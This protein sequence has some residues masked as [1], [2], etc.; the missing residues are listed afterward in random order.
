[1]QYLSLNRSLPESWCEF[2][3]NKP[4]DL[5]S[6]QIAKDAIV[7][8]ALPPARDRFKAFEMVDPDKIRIVIVGQD[9]YHRIDMATGLA[10]SVPS[11]K[12]IPPSLRN[13][14][15]EYVDDLGLRTP[16]H[17]DLS[18]WASRGVLLL[19][20]VLTVTEGR[21]GSLR[22]FGWEALTNHVVRLIVERNHCI[23]FILWGFSAQQL[24]PLITDDH[25]IIKSA[26]PSP[27]SAYRGFFG[28]KPFTR[29]NNYFRKQ[30]LPE[31]NWSLSSDLPSD[32][33]GYMNKLS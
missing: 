15:K 23:A 3:G 32:V 21:A 13:I 22:G 12:P 16:P 4:L 14:F 5:I 30:G 11:R 26:H 6:K 25:F 1:M 10:F 17:G 8:S 19:N 24:I 18:R 9:P 20:R 29:I 33:K 31:F 2:L 28:S 7:S 27:L